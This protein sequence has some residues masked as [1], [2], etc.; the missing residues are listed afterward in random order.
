M[1]FRIREKW[2][3]FKRGMSQVSFIVQLATLAFSVYTALT[4]SGLPQWITIGL[5]MLGFVTGVLVVWRFGAWDF[6]P[7]R[8]RTIYRKDIQVDPW[9]Q[10]FARH[11]IEVAKALHTDPSIWYEWLDDRRGSQ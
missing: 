3:Q 8:P 5:V 11:N 9:W 7:N 1:T 2:S 10:A 6:D 4:V